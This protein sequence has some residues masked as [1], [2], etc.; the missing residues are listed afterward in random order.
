MSSAWWACWGPASLALALAW[1]GDSHITLQRNGP[2]QLDIGGP[3][4]IALSDMVRLRLSVA[5]S[6]DLEVRPLESGKLEP[7]WQLVAG[8]ATTADVDGRKRWQQEV[9]AEPLRPGDLTLELPPL[10]YRYGDGRWHVV[11]WK[12]VYIKVQ[13]SALADVKDLRDITSIEKLPSVSDRSGWSAW[14]APAGG[15]ITLLVLI[16]AAWRWR[17]KRPA[18]GATP[19]DRA[20]RDLERIGALKL[21]EAGKGERFHVLLHDVVRRYLCRRFQI[22]ARARTSAELRAQVA[23]AA[24]SAESRRLLDEFL[25][26]CDRAKFAGAALSPALCEEAAE[27][28]RQIVSCAYLKFTSN[29]R[30]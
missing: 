1:P 17:K 7:G 13:T 19:E 5:G 12:P 26:R 8:K 27:L 22:A 21:V 14:I 3:K 29:A 11:D 25:E 2:A 16:I 23:V 18:V 10:R 6:K 28:A 9:Q 30:H 4:V 15:G 24:M 20:R